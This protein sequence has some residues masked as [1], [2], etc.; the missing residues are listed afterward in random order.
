MV[1]IYSL[2]LHLVCVH[3]TYGQGCANPCSPHCVGP[4][5]SCDP[6]D[7]SCDQGCEPGYQPPRCDQ[8]MT[9]QLFVTE[10]YPME[11]GWFS[12]LYNNGI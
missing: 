10:F 1:M 11:F 7:G 8:G 9:L 2:P 4:D 12:F 6:F 5:H 3:E